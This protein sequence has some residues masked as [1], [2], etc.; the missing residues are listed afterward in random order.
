MG[1]RVAVVGAGIAGLAAAYELARAGVESVVFESDRRAG[2]VIVTE[3]PEPGWVVEGGPDSVLASDTVVPA[4]AREL[5]LAHRLVGQTARG[6]SLWDGSALQAL[7][8][9]EAA[10]LLGIDTGSAA[11]APGFTTFRGGMG[12]LV[13]A[14]VAVAG[15]AIRYGA[16]VTALRPAERG[17]GWRLE[18]AGGGPLEADGLILA[19]P[20]FRAAGLLRSLDAEAAARLDEIRYLPSF[21]VT[22]AYREA[23]FRR[24][25]EG[26][27]FVVKPPVDVTR[28]RAGLQYALVV[29]GVVVTRLMGLVGVRCVGTVQALRA[30]TYASAKFPGRAPP[31]HVLLRA[32]LLPGDHPEQVAHENLAPILGIEGEPLWTRAFS[33]PRGLARPGGDHAARLARLRERL[34]AQPPLALAGGGYEAP[35]VPACVAGGRRAG[36]EMVQRLGG[37]G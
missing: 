13:D 27:G 12:E 32:F 19:V 3:H 8:E 2:G 15:D 14:L 34:M 26:T 11:L 31:G 10:R 33:W 4:L 21:T 29:A 1:V 7:G 36:R 16:R 24:P 23:Q 35:N 9:G 37:G 25:L 20:A 22:L 17:G 30:C 18:V 6:S 5:G 28:L